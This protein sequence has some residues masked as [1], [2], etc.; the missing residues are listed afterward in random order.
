MMQ[1]AII[2]ILIIAFIFG[3]GIFRAWRGSRIYRRM[4]DRPFP[5]KWRVILEARVPFYQRLSKEEK[6][7][8]EVKVHIFLLNVRIIGIKTEATDL[9]RILIASAAT[10]PIFRFPEWH[11]IGLYEVQVF[12]EKFQIP[13]KNVM[14]NGL[15]GWGE[16]EGKMMLSRRA[17]YHGFHDQTDNKNVAVHEFIHLVDKQDGEVDGVLEEV[18][19]ETDISPWLHMIHLKTQELALQDTSIRDYAMA[20][21]AEFLAVVGE[22]FFE[23]PDQMKK[24][25]PVLYKQLDKIFNPQ[26][27]L[28]FGKLQKDV[29][30]KQREACPCGSGQPYDK[31]CYLRNKDGYLK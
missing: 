21:R 20:N 22:Y 26:K 7:L 12:P 3:V 19:H 2:V 13:G 11:Y 8:F 9:D 30:T 17:L 5:E 29:S 28:T 1:E 16:M 25:H 14:A 6:E 27:G 15:V 4:P 24:D 18:M 10:I 31:C 23:N